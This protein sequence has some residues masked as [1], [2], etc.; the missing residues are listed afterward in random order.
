MR[1]FY[2]ALKIFIICGMIFLNL[3]LIPCLLYSVMEYRWDMTVGV[4]FAL[5]W[6]NGISLF[7]ITYYRNLVI[8]VDFDGDTT[9]ITT[10]SKLIC[11]PS[12][13]FVEVID[14]SFLG[15]TILKYEEGTTRK[16]FIFQK[17]YS[18]FKVYSL[19]LIEMKKH[20]THAAF[21]IH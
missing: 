16:R 8:E 19:D 13:N 6:M 9:V 20:M 1:W 4:L 15:R 14:S 17:Q 7:I 11:L 3:I 12:K 10:N 21:K 18:L 5:V 2:R